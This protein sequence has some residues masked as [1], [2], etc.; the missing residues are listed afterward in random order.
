[1]RLK[2]YW[3]L[4]FFLLAGGC[5]LRLSAASYKISDNADFLGG[6]L[7]EVI[8][9]DPDGAASNYI[10]L[11]NTNPGR[12]GNP[13]DVLATD[14]DRVFA[15]K[16]KIS[17]SETRA[18]QR[19]SE[20][21]QL[22]IE[23]IS[24]A[25]SD[26]GDL[27]LTDSN[28]NLV[29]FRILNF[30]Q[31]VDDKNTP[32]TLLFEAN[33]NPSV[34]TEYFL[35]Y[36]N[37]KAIS[38]ATDS[39]SPFYLNN[40]DFE[41]GTTSWA[42]CSANTLTTNNA[43]VL[44][45]ANGVSIIPPGFVGYESK[46]CLLAY[47]P[48]G[49]NEGAE[50]NKWRVWSQSITGPTADRYIAT[51]HKKTFSGAYDK[52]LRTYLRHI[53]SGAGADTDIP[54]GVTDWTTVSL[55]FDT[56]ATRNLEL[57]V[58]MFFGT[59]V[60]T[61]WRERATYID[62]IVVEPKFPLE[63]VLGILEPAGYAP[64][65]SF[66]SPIID[67]GTA[68]PQFKKITWVA[69]TSAPGTRVYFQTRSGATV[70]GLNLAA[71]SSLIDINGSDIPSPS[72]RYLQ[73]RA[74]LE[75]EN[76]AYTPILDEIELFYDLPP[77]KLEV[78]AP[79]S[80]NAG[81]YFDFRVTVLDSLNA[82]ATDFIGTVNLS[83]LP[84]GV[85]FLPGNS[86]NFIAEDQGTAL[87]QGRKTLSEDFEILAT[88][89]GLTDGSSG[90]IV[91]EPN[92]VSQLVFV[93]PPPS[94]TAGN[95]F[96]L[97][98]EAR[99]R[100]GNL[101]SQANFAITPSSS[102]PYPALLPASL[103]LVDGKATLSN[104]KL[105]TAPS[106]TLT[107]L[108]PSNGLNQGLVLGVVPAATNKL[109]LVAEPVQYSNTPFSITINAIDSYENQTSYSGPYSLGIS[110][111][112]I[113]PNSGNIVSGT[114][115]D[116]VAVDQQGTL[117]ITGTSG[118]YSGTLGITSKPQ[119]P[120]SLEAFRVDAGSN[121]IAGIPF[122]LTIEALDSALNRLTSYSG[123]CRLTADIGDIT[124]AYTTSYS[125]LD[126]FMALPV[127]VS[128]AGDPVIITAYDL[129]DNTKLGM[130][131]ITVQAGS[132]DHFDI[133]V[134][135]SVKAGASL[136]F[137]LR[138]RDSSGNLLSRYTGSVSLF[139]TSSGGDVVFPSI[140]TFQAADNGVK[141][142]TAA[143]AA[144]FT[145]AEKIR[146]RA[147][148]SGRTGISTFIEILAASDT[149]QINLVPDLYSI[150]LGEPLSFNL[151]L[152][153]PFENPLTDFTGSVNIAYSGPGV[154]GPLSYSF[155][156]FENGFHRFLNQ[157]RASQLGSFSIEVS[158]PV[159]ATVAS[160][161]LITVTS[162]QT[163][164]FCL[165]P[166]SIN[167][168]AGE[169]FSFDVTAS[170]TA[171]NLNVYYNNSIRF[172]TLDSKAILP[173]DSTLTNGAGNFNATFKTAGTFELAVRD[174]TNPAIVGTMSVT[175]IA[176]DPS[177]LEIDILDPDL[178]VDAGIAFPYELRIYDAFA[179][180]SSFTGTIQI[181]APDTHALA[182]RI[183]SFNP[184]NQSLISDSWTLISA[185][186]QELTATATNLATAT[187]DRL[188]ILAV[189][190]DH[191]SGDFPQSV[192]SE[193]YYPFKVRIEDIY[194]NPTP[195][196][197][198]TI[199]PVSSGPTFLREP[200]NHSFSAGDNGEYVFNLAWDRGTANP[201]TTNLSFQD[202]GAL[203][204]LTF[205]VLV[206]CPR[207]GN[208]VNVLANFWL[209][210]PDQNFVTASQ[211][212]NMV[213]VSSMAR[214]KYATITATIEFQ[215]SNGEF[216]VNEGSGW[217]KT[218]TMT[219][220]SSKSFQAL[221]TRTG[222]LSV[223]ANSAAEP[224]KTGSVSFISLPDV[225]DSV[226]VKAESPQ[227]AGQKFPALIEWWDGNNN[228]AET[229]AEELTKSAIANFSNVLDPQTFLTGG[230]QG[231]FDESVVNGEW[232]DK[233]FWK[234][235][236][237]TNIHHD[238]ILNQISIVGIYDEDFSDGSLDNPRWK[239]MTMTAGGA[240]NGSIDFDEN[241]LRIGSIGNGR[242]W[243]STNQSTF[244]IADIQDSYHYLYM[245]WPATDTFNFD[246]R[247]YVMRY[248]YDT[249]K[250]TNI[251]MVGLLM[252]DDSHANEPRYI[253]SQMQNS[254]N[255]GDFNMNSTSQVT[256]RNNPNDTVRRRRPNT[257]NGNTGTHPKWLR[258]RRTAANAY[259]AAQSNDATVWYPF[260]YQNGTNVTPSFGAGQKIGLA[261]CAG[262]NIYPG[263][264]WFT[265]FKINRFY[266]QGDF[267]SVIYDVG[268][269]SVNFNQ[270]NLVT[271]KPGGTQVRVRIR[272]SNNP[273]AM[274]GWT[275]LGN[276]DSANI[277]A[278][279]NNRYIQYRLTLQP[280]NLAAGVNDATP[281]VKEVKIDYTC[282][283]LGQTF[284][285]RET[286][287]LL[288]SSSTPTVT[289][290]STDV[291]IEGGLVADLKIDAPASVK[292]GEPFTISVSALDAFGNIADNASGT[293]IFSTS[294]G[295]PYPGTVPPAYTLVPVAD[296]GQH[297]FHKMC[298]L[299]NGNPNAT[300]SIT[301]GTIS[302]DSLPILVLPGELKGFDVLANS[303][304]VAS[305]SFKVEV[306]AKDLFDNVKF[307]YNGNLSF[308]DD[309]TGGKSTYNPNGIGAGDWV[310]GVATLSPGVSFTKVETVHVKVQGD[311]RNGI[312]N[313]IQIINAP[314][315]SLTIVV[316]T[317][318]PE[319]GN[320]F[321]IIVKALD[322]FGNI[323]ADYS[324]TVTFST[325]DAHASVILPANYSF[326]PGDA[327][328]HEWIT[329]VKLI[330]PGAQ[331][332]RVEDTV[333]TSMFY[334]MPLTVLPGPVAQF[335][336]SCNGIQTANAPFNLLITA[337]D[338]F[339]N[340]KTNYSETI[341]LTTDF[342]SVLPVTAGG[343]SAGQLLVPS[344][345]LNNAAL[346]A[347]E[348]IYVTAG[349]AIGS[350][351]LE[352]LPSAAIFDHFFLETVPATPTSGDAFKLVIKAVGANG[353]VFT[354]YSGTGA[355][356][357][358]SNSLGFEVNP[359][360][361]PD[362]ATGFTSGIKEVYAR[363]WEAGEI[364]IWA[365]DKTLSKVGSLTLNIAPTNLSYFTLTPGTS[366]TVIYPNVNYQ[367]VN[368]AFPLYLTAYDSLDNV[369]T[370]YFGNAA[371][372][373]NG[374]G[375]LNISSVTFDA[376]QATVSALIYDSWGKIRIT[377]KDTL[378][379]R[380]GIS[381]SIYFFGPL[382]WFVPHYSPDQTDESPFLTT[383][384]AF[385]I[386]GQ[387]KKNC[388]DTMTVTNLDID[389][390]STAPFSVAPVALAL[391]WN[392]G[393]AY[394]WFTPNRKNTGATD[395][396]ATFRIDSN[397]TAG[398]SGTVKIA[399]RPQSTAAMDHFLIETH[400]PQVADE[401]FP[402]AIK[403]VDAENRT[404]TNWSGNI[405]VLASDGTSL[406]FINP[407]T[408][409]INLADNGV[410]A[411]TTAYISAPGTYTITSNSGAFSGSFYPML[412][413][414]K[415]IASLSVVLPEFAPLNQNFTM[416]ISALNE[417]GSVKTDYIPEGPVL[418][419]LN[420]TATGI[421]GVQFIDPSVFVNGVATINT[422]TYNKSQKIFVYA[423]EP[424]LNKDF[425]SG[426]C[427][428]FGV[429]TKVI[430]QTL[431]TALPAN[432]D[433]SRDFFWN[434]FFA[435]RVT[436]KD[437]NGFVVANFDDDI[438]FFVIPGTAPTAA[439]PI[440][441]P[442]YS[443]QHFNSASQ[444]IQDFNFKV[445]Y[446]TMVSPI[447]L[448]L[449][450]SFSNGFIDVTDTTPD[451]SFLKIIVFDHY[452]IDTPQATT[453]AMR[454]AT[455]TFRITAIDNFGAPFTLVASTPNFSWSQTE[456]A[457]SPAN[458]QVLPAVGP[459]PVPF[460]ATS[461]VSFNALINYDDISTTTFRFNITPEDSSPGSATVEFPVRLGEP[462]VSS[463]LINVLPLT[464]YVLSMYIRTIDE[465]LDTGSAHIEVGLYENTANSPIQPMKRL[466][467][468]I[469]ENGTSA[470]FGT[471]NGFHDWKR[472]YWWFDSDADTTKVS[473]K[474][475]VADG[476]IY[477]DGIQL[478]K[479]L[480]SANPIP[481]SFSPLPI[482][483]I[484]PGSDKRT[485]LEGQNYWKK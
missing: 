373:T 377:A 367:S 242:I 160:T 206:D 129:K 158:E 174:T 331:T 434:T 419:K 459:I 172:S 156:A 104:L 473:I 121:Q 191:I 477:I 85:T 414:D 465:A 24:G 268:T 396:T 227:Q 199:T 205:P 335:E 262:S 116:N 462:R 423:R 375:S 274:G 103:N 282:S 438:N 267:T 189:A 134:P 78:L 30:E 285:G 330:T 68:N 322:E 329:A 252:R 18:R 74:F 393:L 485:D 5:F 447:N 301:D 312:S 57:G 454:G 439:D 155:L 38:I 483:L 278:L 39:I 470:N 157:I 281:V 384:E 73:V 135:A 210:L 56:G 347:T 303:P 163:I 169:T 325:S 450:A 272:A 344:T 341:N 279:S 458:L 20:K 319:A 109:K 261:A 63:K 431:D 26:W 52:R 403:A 176:S 293:W 209:S 175:V 378:L 361:S 36:G 446:S 183:K 122:T 392:D 364:T 241:V 126:G 145:K 25:K 202:S 421:I 422:Q 356:L 168:S 357:T 479:A 120:T 441:V 13:G 21:I 92:Q 142:F 333:D 65:G 80:V 229:S 35:Y 265:D 93:A 397:E 197:T 153:D 345:E 127:T 28:G 444:G 244:S 475:G 60:D 164:A 187:S 391:A 102:D 97:N 200:T 352:L 294:D 467:D 308:Y 407:T 83:S 351:S 337:Y 131:Y 253:C 289:P 118:I 115:S 95:L 51:I 184:V 178:I 309:K 360:M 49:G 4:L 271:E 368:D 409:I 317:T 401:F 89:A 196:Y 82:T 243:T 192:Y 11:F 173:A 484:H 235:E 62:W 101:A 370:D 304:Q 353:A 216:W 371:L 260:I 334:E 22:N 113:L 123:A 472:Y 355:D 433:F 152:T 190:P 374:A 471:T 84:A 98:L 114:V 15:K 290:G 476:V 453:G 138:P 257:S 376:G 130:A 339:G 117:T 9:N 186:V 276:V 143:E 307:D 100:Y 219:N 406:F 295:A 380:Q 112:T 237:E 432:V 390:P 291:V 225:L 64:V 443:V 398:A 469:D 342:D 248:W 429:P 159:S 461:Q 436:V 328:V 32:V 86:Y 166:D 314:A 182:D 383:I 220:E 340:L 273:A 81:D 71:W 201:I 96:N 400:S 10:R 416:T 354:G 440:L 468:L 247:T 212:F 413:K 299:N 87:F 140:Y 275:N 231:R 280:N 77:E 435:A 214:D 19:F 128:G 445:D 425:I 161:S 297:T 256:Y 162:G 365:H 386:Y 411:T 230:R 137:A 315:Y 324:G 228:Y 410:F 412:I 284:E 327:G 59:S 55:E 105:F 428:V 263:I 167:L 111:G 385:D 154:A 381:N 286:I 179:N 193:F 318:Q 338:D 418:L 388:L 249:A 320:A 292:A 141:I 53:Q 478:E 79:A 40:H 170:D 300:I 269:S 245:D 3:L 405:N 449:V 343:F 70:A 233:R 171:G 348:R 217:Q 389:P 408:A 326:L 45:I 420:A 148:D 31:P 246:A 404:I 50:N 8:A 255:A 69:N 27:R 464:R 37:E 417:L 16:R 88:S 58:G 287:T 223:V 321:S 482:N 213:L 430:L 215:I 72:Q 415:P 232:V 350:K 23:Q 29:P 204:N 75:S 426:P 457:T 264:G 198:D 124:P 177:V 402:M 67:T 33:A 1:M 424:E 254:T 258:L 222:Y 480:D 442:G 165:V 133:S 394:T 311:T 251:S 12:D 310:N 149:P 437:A 99:D 427:S 362:E 349:T 144:R 399:L 106:Q 372:T 7:A 323:A 382:G 270:I 283:P 313:D 91:C 195:L 460:F 139:N 296:K 132:L 240:C 305:Q 34:T 136:T 358:A 42:L 236:T 346:P 48:E 218:L 369:K 366:S 448:K 266:D 66:T 110:A 6:T 54:A 363:I 238:K 185:G 298:I 379:D 336:L 302:S 119:T 151:S 94:V 194:G 288:A 180:P 208:P 221:V 150:E 466:A 207:S 44:E 61:G 259:E 452:R 455:F 316:S 359:S 203:A 14:S 76:T 46:S 47:Y 107:I 277:S 463:K 239:T 306:T 41:D 125:F 226:T 211:P 250:R 456:P 332:L 147:E 108:A 17:L 43:V 387:T 224:L 481:T 181:T 234:S 395:A 2:I 146:I 474:L 188:K 90:N 451:L